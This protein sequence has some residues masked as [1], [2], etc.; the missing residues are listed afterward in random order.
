MN[1]LKELLSSVLPVDKSKCYAEGTLH[2]E[3]GCMVA[4]E[5]VDASR[6]SSQTSE[7]GETFYLD[8][9][10]IFFVPTGCSRATSQLEQLRKSGKTISDKWAFLRVDGN[11]EHFDSLFEAES[12]AEKLHLS[13]DE[14]C[15]EFIV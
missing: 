9:D 1:Y 13:S 10:P 2:G 7:G 11:L 14:Y 12:R 3:I 15:I 5:S 8:N 4:G 6:Y